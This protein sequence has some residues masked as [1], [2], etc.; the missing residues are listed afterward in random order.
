MFGQ[1]QGKQIL[2][3]GNKIKIKVLHDCFGL[4]LLLFDALHAQ[5]VYHGHKIQEIVLLSIRQLIFYYH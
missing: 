3:D 2:I 1:L 5:V 4:Y